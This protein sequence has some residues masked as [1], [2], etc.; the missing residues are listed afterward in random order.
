MAQPPHIVVVGGGISGL[1]A[2]LRLSERGHRVTVLEKERE[3]GG[4]AGTRV[5]AGT[6]IMTGAG[7]GRKDKD[8]RLCALLKE[9]DVPY[10]DFVVHQQYSRAFGDDEKEISAAFVKRT[11]FDLRRTFKAAGSPRV[12]F[13]S[14]AES[15]LGPEVYARFVA[16]SGYSDYEKEDVLDTLYHYGFDDNF[17]AWNA[18]GIS[19]KDL[20]QA[21]KKKCQS[22]GRGVRMFCST[23]VL[24][25]DRDASSPNM[26]VEIKTNEHHK[27]IPCNGI[28][29]ATTVDTVRRLLPQFQIYRHIHGQPFLRIYGQFSKGCRDL[30]AS[31][32]STTTVVPGP[33]HKIIPMNPK[34]GIYMIA[35]SDNADAKKVER[36]MNSKPKL[37]RLLER[38]LGLSNSDQVLE[39]LQ[40]ELIPWPVGTHYYGVLPERFQ[41]RRAFIKEA[42]HPA[43]NVYVVG[44]MV[45]MNQG[46]VEGALES[47]DRLFS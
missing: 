2:A 8:T 19:W 37:C 16:A 38:S 21:L 6:T 45:S 28:V 42:Q 36:I 29:L 12:T 35:Y 1:Y 10:T 13:K 34:K 24:S 30:V 22:R 32:V 5:F 46:W 39:L 43:Q 47:V 40:T 14:F 18:M 20:V 15:V 41:T 27:Y 33:L 17:T 7:V 3:M 44:E 11:F 25:L 23:E 26:S 4:R 9:L 31:A